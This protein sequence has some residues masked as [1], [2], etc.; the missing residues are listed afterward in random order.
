MALEGTIDYS[1]S[2]STLS[3]RERG[4]ENLRKYFHI[5]HSYRRTHEQTDFLTKFHLKSAGSALKLCFLRIYGFKQALGCKVL[6]ISSKILRRT[7]TK[8]CQIPSNRDS[9]TKGRNSGPS[10][11]LRT[12]SKVSIKRIWFM[13][14][15]RTG[16]QNLKRDTSGTCACA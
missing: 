1:N 13:G 3:Q 15:Y 6:E 12:R 7:Y 9:S 14:M 2:I 8:F 16:K 10:S 5:F 4:R 11:R